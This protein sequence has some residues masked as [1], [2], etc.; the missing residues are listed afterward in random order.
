MKTLVIGGG[1]GGIVAASTLRNE[2]G[3]GHEV[4]L[5]SRDNDFYL[6]AAFPRLAF[7]GTPAPEEIRLPLDEVFPPRG[8]NFRQATVTAIQ[9]DANRIETDASQ[10]SYD[11]LIIALGTRYASEKIPGLQ[12]HSASLWTV[13]AAQRL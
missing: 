12:A 5:V 6:R 13:D 10:L 3:E 8:I 11:Y 7:E 4:T 1:F 2:L 9:P